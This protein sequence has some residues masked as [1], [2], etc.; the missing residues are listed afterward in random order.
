MFAI[1]KLLTYNLNLVMRRRHPNAPVRGPPYPILVHYSGSDNSIDRVTYIVCLHGR[2]PERYELWSLNAR[3]FLVPAHGDR[4]Y[5]TP[6]RW[7]RCYH[8]RRPEQDIK[9]RRQGR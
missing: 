1:N 4:Q 7:Y 3:I 8:N 9:A 5:R 6:A 2:V